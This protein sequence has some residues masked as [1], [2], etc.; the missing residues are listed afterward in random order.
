MSM[1]GNSAHG[2]VLLGTLSITASGLGAMIALDAAIALL[3]PVKPDQ[4]VHYD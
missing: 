2:Q 1:L 4:R 3:R